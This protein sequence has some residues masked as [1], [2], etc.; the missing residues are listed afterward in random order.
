MNKVL[1]YDLTS[2]AQR[3]GWFRSSLNRV[4]WLDIMTGLVITAVLIEMV[5]Q[6]IRYEL[7]I[8]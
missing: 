2:K 4:S 3:I 5:G 1:S 8:K 6:F 7:F